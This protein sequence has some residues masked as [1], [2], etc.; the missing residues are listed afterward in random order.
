M[1]DPAPKE[2]KK[3]GSTLDEHEAFVPI[4][5]LELL[6]GTG[7]HKGKGKQRQDDSFAHSHIGNGPLSGQALEEEYVTGLFTREGR[8]LKF[9]VQIAYPRRNEHLKK[10]R[11]CLFNPNHGIQHN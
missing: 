9:H 7:P 6:G 11:V 5:D 2:K 10:I 1:R 3:R 4:E 8:R